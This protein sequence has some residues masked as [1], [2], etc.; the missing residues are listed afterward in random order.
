MEK[1]F[2][3]NSVY[4]T[5]NSDS[6]SLNHCLWFNISKAFILMLW[7]D[8]ASILQL[9]FHQYK[10]F[11]LINYI[12]IYLSVQV[13]KNHYFP[14]SVRSNSS[15]FP[16]NS[17]VLILFLLYTKLMSSRWKFISKVVFEERIFSNIEPIDMNIIVY[18]SY[19]K[20]LIY[21]A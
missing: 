15:D 2:F 11:N 9:N 13:V 7:I 10:F 16:L 1:F 20:C 6:S 19:L 14:Y 3:S 8:T 4:R 21:K 12:H 17:Y 18:S 5:K